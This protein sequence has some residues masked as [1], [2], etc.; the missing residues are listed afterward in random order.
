MYTSPF[1]CCDILSSALFLPLSIAL[2]SVVGCPGSGA[3]RREPLCTD[4][5]RP[6]FSSIGRPPKP[7]RSCGAGALRREPPDVEPPKSLCLEIFYVAVFISEREA[8]SAGSRR[9]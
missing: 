1:C 2:G 4:P 8:S 5:A 7:R 3:D 6:Q 9:E